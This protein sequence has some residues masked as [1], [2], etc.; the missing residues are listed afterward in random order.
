MLLD[1]FL[2]YQGQQAG[3][4]CHHMVI[5]TWIL[6]SHS[7]RLCAVCH[8][9]ASIPCNCIHVTLKIFHAADNGLEKKQRERSDM[10]KH[11]ESRLWYVGSGVIDQ[12]VGQTTV[13]NPELVGSKRHGRMPLGWK[14]RK[15]ATTWE[16]EVG[17]GKGAT[18]RN[19]VKVIIFCCS[20]FTE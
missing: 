11:V 3:A 15:E 2:P 7:V 12:F 5:L 19:C 10:K 16:R 6:T 20:L 9:S 1:S 18:A 17:G 14:G 4:S 8:A 13:C